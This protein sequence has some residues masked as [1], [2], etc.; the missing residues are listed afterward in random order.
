M[1]ARADRRSRILIGLGVM[2]LIAAGVYYH[3]SIKPRLDDPVRSLV[4]AAERSDVRFVE[5]RLYGFT[6]RPFKP[7]GGHDQ[8]RL[9]VRG[10]ALRVAQ[11]AGTPAAR[12]RATGYLLAGNTRA[13]IRELELTV[14]SHPGDATAWNDLAVALIEAGRVGDAE[15]LPRALAAAERAQIIDPASTAARYNYGVALLRMN[16][17][18]PALKAFRESLRTE[19]DESWATETLS[20]LDSGPVQPTLALWR[21]VAP[22]LER[23]IAAR[24]ASVAHSIIDQYK[25]Q[26]RGQAEVEFLADWG[27]AKAVGDESTAARKLSAARF[28]GEHLRQVTGDSLLYDAAA[29]IADASPTQA[30]LLGRAHVLYRRARKLQHERKP[31][32]ALP[33]FR[34]TET[35]FR[36]ADSPMQNVATYWIANCLSDGAAAAVALA[37]IRR[38]RVSDDHKSLRGLLAWQE[39]TILNGSGYSSEALDAYER[40]FSIFDNIG[41]TNS[42]TYMLNAIA[43]MHRNLGRTTEAWRVRYL[44]FERANGSGQPDLLQMVVHTAARSE[45]AAGDFHVGHVLLGIAAELPTSNPRLSV[46]APLWRGLAA[47]RMGLRKSAERDLEVARMRAGLVSDVALRA[48]VENDLRL[49]EAMVTADDWQSIAR[50]TEYIQDAARRRDSFL[51]PNALVERSRAYRRLRQ[52]DLSK[53]D[54]NAALEEFERRGASIAAPDYRDR[55]FA[56]LDEVVREFVD[57]VD[58]TEGAVNALT[59]SERWRDLGVVAGGPAARDRKSTRLVPAVRNRQLIVR[60]I[61]LTD[62]LL[63]FSVSAGGIR[64]ER[65]AITRSA[66]ER[67]IASFTASVQLGRLDRGAA[68]RLYQLLLSRVEIPAGGAL[69]V[70]PDPVL[71]ALPFAALIDPADGRYLF[72][73]ATLTFLAGLP[74]VAVEPVPSANHRH[75]SA[76]VVGNPA[77][78]AKRFDL[79][80]LPGAEAEARDIGQLYA[81]QPLLGRSASKDRVIAGLQASR[82]VHVA[83]HAVANVSNPDESFVVLATAPDGSSALY[84]HE[85][86]RLSLDHVSLAVIAGCQ[87]AR[88]LD[89][90]RIFRNLAASFVA[91]GAR[92]ALGTLWDLDDATARRVSVGLHRRAISGIGVAAAL[93]D[94]QLELLR[95][96][97][98]QLSAPTNW[99]AL[100]LYGQF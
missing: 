19:T 96:K 10:A 81:V 75:A 24:E 13:A 63:V 38:L 15:A 59:T 92:N 20:R 41:D 9:A 87:T 56:S 57:L 62:R 11:S 23:A 54:L 27:E 51:L 2:V 65:I 21:G 25:Q 99:A 17:K 33:L 71:D 49:A 22:R 8:D 76:L 5:G 50:W 37:T 91:A 32:S 98:P 4:A 69:A 100:R 89:S 6:Q 45:C 74:R 35:L 46:D 66:L 97:D 52:L 58:Q 18:T 73:K 34:E 80:N 1:P 43:A 39:A 64:H 55:Y 68:K 61:V 67:L 42:A 44:A 16:L 48:S 93:R 83:A 77:F 90:P 95:A 53:T 88:S 82:V 30:E 28:V 26:S 86:A 36:H 29:H 60:Y 79:P 78:D 7:F 94:V 47:N 14:A 70:V 85:I 84:L 72:E 31:T 12:Q 3:G 40:A